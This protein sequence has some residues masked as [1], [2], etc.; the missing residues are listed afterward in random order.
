[1]EKLTYGCPATPGVSGSP[2]MRHDGHVIGM[3]TGTNGLVRD[4]ISVNTLKSIFRAWLD[5]YQPNVSVLFSVEFP[6]KI[7]ICF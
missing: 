7:F 1:M 3:H 2:V 4:G 5:Q 6:H